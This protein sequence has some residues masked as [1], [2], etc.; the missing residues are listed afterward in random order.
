MGKN[1][2][3]PVYLKVNDKESVSMKINL[4]KLSDGTSSEIDKVYE[5]SPKQAMTL[6][7]APVVTQDEGQLGITINIDETTNDHEMDITV[8]G[9]WK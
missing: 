8:P 9:E 3:D 4:V 5:L 2:T 7:L 1:D 6:K